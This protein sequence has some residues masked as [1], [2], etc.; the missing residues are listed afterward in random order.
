MTKHEPM[1]SNA[2][3]SARALEEAKR[4]GKKRMEEEAALSGLFKTMVKLDIFYSNAP[5]ILASVYVGEY[6]LNEI[7]AAASRR[8]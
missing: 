2:E 7:R 6:Y 8:P 3:N 5:E 4:L 1:L